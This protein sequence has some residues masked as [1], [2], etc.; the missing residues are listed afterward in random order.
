VTGLK[1]KSEDGFQLRRLLSGQT[2]TMLFLSLNKWTLV[3]AVQIE[4]SKKEVILLNRG[5]SI[6]ITP[7]LLSTK[8]RQELAFAMHNCKLFRQYSFGNGTFNEPRSHGELFCCC[9]FV[10]LYVS[11]LIK[12]R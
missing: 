12:I 5:G 3:T 7:D 4:G 8:R 11:T 9:C 6:C 1:E 2:G 10:A